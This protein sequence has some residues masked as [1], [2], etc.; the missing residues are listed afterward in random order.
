MSK[1]LFLLHFLRDRVRFEVTLLKSQSSDKQAGSR[2]Q[3]D[4]PTSRVQICSR[5]RSAS[6]R[7]FMF[8]AAKAWITASESESFAL[9]PEMTLRKTRFQKDSQFLRNNM[10]FWRLFKL[11][12]FSAQLVIEKTTTTTTTIRIKG[13]QSENKHGDPIFY[14]Y[15]KNYTIR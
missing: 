11:R 10:N 7:F 9:G 1:C 12:T 8:S 2:F 5:A 3:I 13:A 15:H 6:G 14:Q 4:L